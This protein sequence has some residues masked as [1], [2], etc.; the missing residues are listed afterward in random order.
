MKASNPLP[1]LNGVKPSVLVLPHESRFDGKPL[2]DFLCVKFPFVA[3]QQWIMRLNSGM[4]V[5]QDGVPMNEHTVFQAG[6]RIF[7]YREI[8]R[9][10]EP[11]IPFE[12]QI[13]WCDHDLI[14]VD[15]PHFLPVIPSGRFL[16]E[17]LLT[18]LRLR[19]DLQHLAVADITPI[20]RLDKDTA[21]VM[22]FS[23]NPATRSAYQTLFQNKAI[24]KTYH[25]IAPTR[26]DLNYP[27]HIHSRLVTGDAFFLTQQIDGE[28]NSHTRLDLL[29]NRG[30]VSLYELQPI[31][32]KKHQL[33]VHMMS[34]GMPILHDALYPV[35]HE[36]GSEDYNKPLKL[37]AKRIEFADPVSGEYRVFESRQ[38]LN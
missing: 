25:A 12:E 32:G 34:L 10:D 4:V 33:R 18:R 26:T 22:L 17:T 2:L 38:D 31:S 8:S 7:Y 36:V 11:R 28:P 35:V 37:L 27:L 16:R 9:D 15:K 14:V 5:G 21:G 3:K 29:E 6:A 23:H 24:H 20:H 1:I 30:E 19:A 13:L